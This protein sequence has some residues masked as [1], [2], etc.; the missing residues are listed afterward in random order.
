M[1]KRAVSLSRWIRGQSRERSLTSVKANLDFQ[2]IVYTNTTGL[3][4]CCGGQHSCNDPLTNNTYQAPPPAQLSVIARI[5]EAVPSTTPS[6]AAAPSGGVHLSTW[7]AVGIAVGGSVLF[8]LLLGVAIWRVMICRRTRS[9][10]KR[11]PML[12]YDD[13][14][15]WGSYSGSNSRGLSAG[16]TSNVSE[17]SDGRDAWLSEKQYMAP[18]EMEG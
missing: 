17:L 3:W 12:A 18:R 14:V 4:T 11:A 6:A 8:L 15:A 1:S 13:N 7:T 10:A 16:G 5:S 9:L 2:D